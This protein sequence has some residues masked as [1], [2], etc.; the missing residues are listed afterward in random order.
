MTT[1][2]L[3]K[4]N[5]IQNLVYYARLAVQARPWDRGAYVISDLAVALRAYDRARL[6][7][8]HARRRRYRGD[9]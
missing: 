2:P 5:P 4:R 3:I 8:I 1:S 6:G 7:R 9:S